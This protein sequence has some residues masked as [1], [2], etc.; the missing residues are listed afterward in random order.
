MVFWS[1]IPLARGTLPQNMLF[2]SN[3]LKIT[4]F[5]IIQAKRSFVK[6]GDWFTGIS[7][8]E[9]CDRVSSSIRVVEQ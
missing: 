8:F 3:T 2:T 5:K 7:R 9:L 6:S 1:D 4:Q